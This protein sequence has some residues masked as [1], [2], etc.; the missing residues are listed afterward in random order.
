MGEGSA[1][2]YRHRS[3][4]GP[5]RV[6]RLSILLAILGL[7]LAIALVARA[8]VG[9][10]AQAVL[11]VGW[12]GFGLLLLAQAG[13][14]LALGLAWRAVVPRAAPGAAPGAALPV[15]IWGRMV[16]DGATTCLPF[17]PVGGYVF[18]AR[19]ATLAGLSWPVA[20]AG[21]IVDVA[22]EIIAQGLFALAGLAVLLLHRPDS[23]VVG[24]ARPGAGLHLPG[25][26]AA[27]PVPPPPGLGGPRRG[28][29]G[30]GPPVHRRLRP[31]RPH[32]GGA[33][34]IDRPAPQFRGWGR[35]AHA[36]LARHRGCD[37]ADL[38]AAGAGGGIRHRAWRSR[39][40]CT[41]W[42]A[43]PSWCRAGPACRRRVMPGW[44]RCSASRRR[45]RWASACCAGRATPP[46]ASRCCW[47]GSLS[48]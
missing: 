7:C 33:G 32:R 29:E 28:G 17:S 8:D 18:G 10:V 6:R 16:R 22:A 11:S 24:A 21:T 26:G 47:P 15:L 14:F 39:R 23:G 2:R 46:G 13:L 1:R 35:A 9:Q 36:R 3:G 12:G 19:A 44:A 25:P 4:H 43:P 37:L 42:S 48:S 31:V 41:R 30:G 34:P 5:A 27:L 20:A 40:W 38:P 45:S